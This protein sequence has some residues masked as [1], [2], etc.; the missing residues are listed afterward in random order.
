M[1]SINLTFDGRAFVLTTDHAASSYSVPVLVD[2][3]GVAYGPR[4]AVFRDAPTGDGF[5]D[6]FLSTELVTATTIVLGG[7]M[8]VAADDGTTRDTMRRR[9]FGR[10]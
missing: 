3:N 1:G 8:D 5:A 6:L 2:A 9:F 10:A 7:H 4:D